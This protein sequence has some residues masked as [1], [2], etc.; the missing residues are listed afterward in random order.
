MV[1]HESMA[2]FAYQDSEGYWTIA[3]GRCIDRRRGEGLSDDECLYLL[4]NDIKK[5]I[6]DLKDYSWYQIQNEVRQYVLI[7]MHIEMGLEGLLKFRDMLSA[8]N[9]KNY[10]VASNAMASSEWAKQVSKDRVNNM[11]FRMMRGTYP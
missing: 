3:I 10:I 6:N 2:N 9:Y 11:R 7:E 5:A 1:E 8:L 4:N